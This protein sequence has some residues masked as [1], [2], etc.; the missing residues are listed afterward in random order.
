[1]FLPPALCHAMSTPP[2]MPSMTATCRG[3]MQLDHLTHLMLCWQLH[4]A[5]LQPIRGTWQQTSTT[6]IIIR[7]A[8]LPSIHSQCCHHITPLTYHLP[9]ALISQLGAASPYP[10]FTL[11]CTTIQMSLNRSEPISVSSNSFSILRLMRI[12]VHSKKLGHSSG[13]C[14]ESRCICTCSF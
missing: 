11:H 10:P 8:T 5:P 1:M 13:W 4:L 12:P 3:S 14:K 9:L 7:Q 6:R 2:L